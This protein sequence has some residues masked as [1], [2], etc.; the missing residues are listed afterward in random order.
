MLSKMS[1]TENRIIELAVENQK[2]SGSLWKGFLNWEF[3]HQEQIKT[4]SVIEES[5][6]A[7]W[8]T[9]KTRIC[10][11]NSNWGWGMLQRL[12]I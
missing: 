2:E 10:M 3:S 9:Y 6:F 12:W 8:N 5:A 11:S 4:D 7:K 1:S